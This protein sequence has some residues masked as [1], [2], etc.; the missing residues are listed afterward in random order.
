[1]RGIFSIWELMVRVGLKVKLHVFNMEIHGAGWV[2][3]ERFGV[4]ADG[5]LAGREVCDLCGRGELA[6]PVEH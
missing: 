6:A 1:M 3:K 5:V 4:W 2:E